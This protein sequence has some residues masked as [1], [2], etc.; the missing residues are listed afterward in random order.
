MVAA[1]T[2][3]A[4]VMELETVAEYVESDETKDLIATLGVDY[5]QGYAIGKPVP[6]Q[7]VLVDLSEQKK[8]STGS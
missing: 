2:E 3:V 4:R 1:I 8:K 5:A 6:L 7:D